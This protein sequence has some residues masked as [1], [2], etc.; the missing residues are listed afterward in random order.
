MTTLRVLLREPPRPDRADPWALLDEAGAL[1]REGCDPPASWPAA[2][3]R[4]AVVAAERARLVILT[5]PPLP[6]ARLP[7]AVAYALE[8][9]L[10]SGDDP[11]R[12]A[13]GPQHADGRV[14]AAVASR[15]LI[16][17]LY[18]D[19]HG[20]TRIVPEAALV[21]P[22]EAWGWYASGAGGSFVRTPAGSFA[23]SASA[24]ALPAELVVALAQAR[25]AGASP[26]AVE[27]AFD[28]DPAQLARF[29][30]DT[31]VAFT[32]APTWRWT[33]AGTSGSALPDW[34]AEAADGS[35]EPRATLQPFRLAAGLAAAALVLHVTA[36]LVEWASLRVDAWRTERAIVGVAAQAGVADTSSASAAVA[37]LVRRHADARH[38]AGL[39]APGD[40]LPLLGQ[41]APALAD[42]PRGALKS[43]TY[44]DGAWTL[45]LAKVDAAALAAVDRGLAARGLVALQAP[46]ATGVRMRLVAEP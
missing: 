39:A 24:D 31:G 27:V 33:D 1:V 19:A 2:S 12:V 7:Q 32:R 16:D 17:G 34:R 21:P 43:A 14:V 30:S 36:T 15:A 44:T 18:G 28:A 40:A 41:A 4:E 13:R 37:G 46:T 6:P 29:G 45:E 22:T 38:R 25:R 35:R 9:Q 3:L 8:D 10:A 42:L 23:A 5:L 11:P 26:N 20:W